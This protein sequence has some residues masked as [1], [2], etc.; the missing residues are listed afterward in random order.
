MLLNIVERLMMHKKAR[1][2]RRGP[3]LGWLVSRGVS[4][5]REGIPPRCRR[6]TYR[7]HRKPVR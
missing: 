6:R 4:S 7:Q 5:G 2:I 3:G 1:G